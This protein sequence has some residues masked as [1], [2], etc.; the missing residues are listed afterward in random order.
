[1]DTVASDPLSRTVA[2]P[3]PAGDVWSEGPRALSVDGL[4]GGCLVGL[5]TSR[6]TVLRLTE[7]PAADSARRMASSVYPVAYR[8]RISSA[9][10]SA[11]RVHRPGGWLGK[12]RTPPG[13][14]C[15][16]ALEM[17]GLAWVFAAI[18]SVEPMSFKVYS[19]KS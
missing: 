14:T 9:N 17:V 19:W 7:T 6:W 12:R 3:I 10:V 1:M 5:V 16:I 18:G 8:R 4:A 13:P 11:L 2:S 15:V